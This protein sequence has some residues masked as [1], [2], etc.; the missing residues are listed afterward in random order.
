MDVEPWVRSSDCTTHL[1]KGLEHLQI[2]VSVEGEWVVEPIPHEYQG[3]TVFS[4]LTLNTI[5]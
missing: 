5:L 2:W 1:Y 3:T 4:N